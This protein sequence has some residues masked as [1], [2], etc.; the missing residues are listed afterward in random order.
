VEP[1]IVTAVAG[2]R[3]VTAEVTLADLS[4]RPGRYEVAL[5]GAAGEAPVRAGIRIGAG[6]RERLRLALP[7]ASGRL[8][9]RV[10]GT[11]TTAA[12]AP[13][14]PARPAAT[15]ADA[16]GRPEVR[17][18]GGLAE[19]LVQIG[20]L[21]RADGRVKNVRLH[22]VRLSLVPAGGGEPLPVTGRKQAGAWPAG[23][24]RFLVARRLASG[25]DVPAGAYRLRIT[26][27]GPDGTA[28]SRESGPFTLD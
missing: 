8:V 20:M 12:E 27:A 15:P 25:A 19:V 1:A 9:V 7:A 4:G 24:Y 3:G 11:R 2:R 17:A 16:L 23:S 5:L 14:L 10:A 26:A 28:L 13:V 21:R 18:D 6:G 22:G